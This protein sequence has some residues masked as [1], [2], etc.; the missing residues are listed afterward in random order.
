VQEIVWDAALHELVQNLSTLLQF[1]TTNP[2]GNE[3]LAAEWI[4]GILHREGIEA[5]IVQSAPGRGTVI[6][7][8]RAPQPQG[9]G[10]LLMGHT[11]VVPADPSEWQY[12]PFSGAVVNGE[13]WGRGALDMKGTV[14]TWLSLILLAKRN[15]LPLKR[16]IIFMANA[17]EET[18]GEAGAGYVAD[19]H[20]DKVR[21]A[22]GLS[23]GGGGVTEFNGVSYFTYQVAEK[24]SCKF[25]MI[26]R[27]AGGHASVPSPDNAIVYLGRA[28][29]ALGAN[30]LPV[31]ITEPFRGFVEGV[32]ARQPEP[33]RSAWLRI[34]SDPAHADEHLAAA[35]S[36]DA[37]LQRRIRAMMCNTATPTMLQAGSKIN[38]IPASAECSVD[39]RILPGQTRESF[40]AEVKAVLAAAGVLEK[41][42]LEWMVRPIK[43]DSPV[44]HPLV[45]AMRAALAKHAP[46]VPL[47]PQMS[48]G[49]TDNEYFRNLGMPIYGFYP[50]LPGEAASTVHA[51]N[52]RITVKGLEFGLK[53]SWD[54]LKAFCEAQ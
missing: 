33:Q 8:L 21:G 22:G 51:A 38:V 14:A 37:R 13:V 40:E 17:D 30:P 49:G 44:A 3:T 2:P 10:L 36:G 47:I 46:G 28:I 29:A 41:I 5:E 19:Y 25:K 1:D 15:V 42:E 32:A 34:L 16:D 45:D 48:T 26:A 54:V 35:A 24:T 31:H 9:E 18:G 12:P 53:V 4:A 43:K 20:F 27:G 6:G 50:M 52:E 23:E 11:D 7:R 39:G